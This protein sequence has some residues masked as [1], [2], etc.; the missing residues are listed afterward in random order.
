MNNNDH[1]CARQYS[2]WKLFV[3]H[4]KEHPEEP[5]TPLI[6]KMIMTRQIYDQYKMKRE[7]DETFSLH[8]IQKYVEL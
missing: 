4:R 3:T 6:S 8:H 5:G 7:N 2:I 1:L